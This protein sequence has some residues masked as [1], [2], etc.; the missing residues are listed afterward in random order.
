M[1][2]P[3]SFAV[4]HGEVFSPPPLFADAA[5]SV[6]HFDRSKGISCH[7]AKSGTVFLMVQVSLSNKQQVNVGR[8]QDTPEDF[9]NAKLRYKKCMS[10]ANGFEGIEGIPLDVKKRMDSKSLLDN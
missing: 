8:F 7:V 1:T 6:V 5:K 9:E 3:P 4:L 10:Y 2:S